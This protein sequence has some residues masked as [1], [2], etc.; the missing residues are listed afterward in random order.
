MALHARGG[1]RRLR[2]VTALRRPGP[3]RIGHDRGG[4]LPAGASG[5]A[6]KNTTRLGGANPVA[7]AAA[8][9]LATYP[10]LT[11]TTRPQAVVLVDDRDWPAALA[12]SALASAPLRAPLLYSEGSTLPALSAQALAALKPTGW[13]GWAAPQV[14]E[15]GPAAAPTGY[16]TLRVAGDAPNGPLN[17]AGPTSREAAA[18]I[19]AA[20]AAQVERLVAVLQGGPS[21]RVIVVG[22][23]GPPALAMPAAG[24]AAESGAP[25][26]PVDAT[27]IPP[28]TT[29]ALAHL[30]RP[31]I[32][33]VGSPAAVSHTVLVKLARFGAVRR[34]YPTPGV[35][36]RL[37]RARAAKIRQTTRSPWRATPTGRSAGRWISP[38][39][40]WCSHSP[41][42]RWTPPPR[43]RCR[44]T[45]TTRRCCYWN[46]PTRFRQ[47]LREYLG[48]I[49]PAYSDTPEY[50]PVRG[51]YNHGWLIGDDEAI[52][53]TVQ[54]ELDAMLEIAPQNATGSASPTAAASAESSTTPSSSQRTVHQ[55]NQRPHPM[56]QAEDPN[57]LE[58]VSEHEVTV[59]DV[60]QLMGA[61]TPHFAL[62]LR[63]RIVAADRGPPREPPGAG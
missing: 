6:T 20:L 43:R 47:A 38:A 15:I 59:E 58:R 9:A 62:Q 37:G 4:H 52:T 34:I 45:A 36:A 49:K 17:S 12:A 11:P 46:T 23:D 27:G 63:E 14:I 30:H 3:R 28:A 61:S 41:P 35:T 60:R 40:A 19:P 5:L 21:R 18:G 33:A 7:D 32:Y 24:L 51:A 54:A 10:G 44:Q 26:L 16:R 55:P 25:V 56:S 8:V 53:P 13:R 1:A 2:Q 22:A 57:R 31:A 39:T 50:Q 29:R 48:D 42:A